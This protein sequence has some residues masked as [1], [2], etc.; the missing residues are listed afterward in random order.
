MNA[1]LDECVGCNS[2]VTQ[3]RTTIRGKVLILLCWNLRCIMLSSILLYSYFLCYFHGKLLV[4]WLVFGRSH[5]YAFILYHSGV[6]NALHAVRKGRGLHQCVAR[7]PPTD[8]LSLLDLIIERHY[9]IQQID[10]R[11]FLD[12][13]EQGHKTFNKYAADFK[14]MKIWIKSFLYIF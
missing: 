1:T 10:K 8:R 4:S 13:H 12:W 14:V 7:G 9:S 6:H 11:L 5:L 2:P 3:M